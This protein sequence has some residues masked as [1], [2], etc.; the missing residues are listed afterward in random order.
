VA[1]SVEVSSDS[2]ASTPQLVGLNRKLARLMATLR[3]RSLSGTP[4]TIVGNELVAITRPVYGS[5]LIA[6]RVV[7]LPRSN[8]PAAASTGIDRP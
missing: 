4:L 5:T 1:L 6:T 7:T 8:G 3:L 2:V